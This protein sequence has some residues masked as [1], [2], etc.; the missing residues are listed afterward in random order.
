[1]K[2]KKEAFMVSVQRVRKAVRLEVR[3]VT[4]EPGAMGPTGHAKDSLFLRERRGAME[5][6]DRVTIGFAI[7]MLASLLVSRWDTGETE[8]D[9]ACSRPLDGTY[10]SPRYGANE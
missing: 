9:R 2:N 10:S 3:E 5:G 7:Q 6:M 1:M 4:E 8:A